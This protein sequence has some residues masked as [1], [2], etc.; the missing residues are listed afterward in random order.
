M[1]NKGFYFIAERGDERSKIEI[2]NMVNTDGDTIRNMVGGYMEVIARGQVNGVR[3]ILI[4][5][6]E[7]RLVAEPRV[8]WAAADFAVSLSRNPAFLFQGVFGDCV[9]IADGDE[10]WRAMDDKEVAKV[11]KYLEHGGFNLVQMTA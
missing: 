2:T 6:E 1:S 8:N 7:A 9:L 11:V 10:D 4:G 5:H 3:C